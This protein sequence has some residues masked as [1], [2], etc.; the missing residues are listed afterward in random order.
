M[1]IEHIAIWTENLELLKDFYIRHFG[2][3]VSDR[4]ENP[5]KQFASYFLSFEDG[6]RIEIMTRTGIKC[7]AEPP[8][9]GLAHFAIIVESRA[10]VDSFTSKVQLAGVTVAG[11]PRVTGDGYYESVILDPD[12]NRIEI[13]AQ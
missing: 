3:K 2:C 1:R 10:I 6:A 9:A 8:V 13:A 12:G 7:N 5:S 11:Q 4:Y